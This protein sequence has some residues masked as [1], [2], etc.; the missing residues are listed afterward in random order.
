MIVR[1]FSPGLFA[2]TPVTSGAGVVLAEPGPATHDPEAA[3]LVVHGSVRIAAVDVEVDRVEVLRGVQLVL[4][5]GMSQTC[6]TAAL[7]GS[8]ALFPD[9]I[10]DVG[11]DLVSSFRCEIVV[12]RWMG[13]AYLH[14]T[15][16]HHVSNVVRVHPAQGAR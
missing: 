5:H 4:V 14:A 11:G 13:P 12:A 1:A 15:F 6:F 2:E 7:A 16:R 3:I 10:Q 9:D 8:T